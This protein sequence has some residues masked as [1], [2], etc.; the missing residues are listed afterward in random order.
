M[1]AGKYKYYKQVRFCTYTLTCES[2]WH[3]WV[4]SWHCHI[5]IYSHG[6]Y[7]DLVAVLLNIIYSVRTFI[8]IWLIIS[9]SM[10]SSYQ[11]IYTH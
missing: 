2:S 7:L 6:C 3:E 9:G 4:C 11:V 10:W 5:W 8:I 1:Q